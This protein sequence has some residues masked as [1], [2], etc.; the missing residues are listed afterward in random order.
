[1]K[2][3][4]TVEQ[5]RMLADILPKES[6]DMCYLNDG[7]AIKIDAIS[8]GVAVE[9]L[10]EWYTDIIPCWS[11][12]ALLSLIAYPSLGQAIN[13]P[14]KGKW[15]VHAVVNPDGDFTDYVT[16]VYDTPIEACIDAVTELY[17]T[18][19]GSKG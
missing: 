15:Y 13:E 18:T 12:G 11:L 9:V 4:T 3:V 2:Q 17:S 5:S 19:K 6:A 8:Y 16:D 14:N 1:M 10:E 7:T